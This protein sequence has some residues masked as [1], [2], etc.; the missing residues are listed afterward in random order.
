MRVCF[1]TKNN[2]AARR[3]VSVAAV[4][5]TGTLLA[6]GSWAATVGDWQTVVNNGDIVPG[7]T[8][9]S[10]FSYNQPS[11]SSNGLV[12]FRARARTPGGGGGGGEPFR[13]IY[14]RDMSVPGQPIV[15]I[16]DNKSSLVP[17]P[18]NTGSGFAEFPSFPRIDAA[19][20]VAF[21]G[22]SQPVWTYTDANG[23]DTK[24]GTSGVY[25]AP[26]GV[27]VTGA[28]QLGAVPGFGHASVPGSAAAGTKFDQ[29][30]GAPSPS[31]SLVAFKGNWTDAA[32][33][34][35]GIYVR[36][37]LAGGGTD[38]VRFIAESG[39]AIPNEGGSAGSGAVFGSTAP[40]STWGNKVVFTGLDNEDAPTAGGI[41]IANMVGT[42]NLRPLV[43]F[44]TGVP[45]A[46]GQTFNK[47]GEALSYD[48]NRV[49][50]WAAWGD[51]MRTV[52][53]TCSTDGNAAVKQACMD[54]SDK[55]PVT[56]EA[57]G[58]TTRDVPVNQGIFVVNT[59][60]GVVE[61][62]A[63]TGDAG[64]SD[65]L[66][67]NFSGAPPGVGEGEGDAEAPRWRSTSF[68][69]VDGNQ[70]IFKAAG[71]TVQ[72]LMLDRGIGEMFATLVDTTMLA[73]LLDPFAQ[74][75]SVI[76]SF[77]IERDG[78]RAGRIAIN[79][80][81]LNAADEGWAGIYTAN[82][83]PIPLP[84]PLLL[85]GAALGSLNLLRR[86]RR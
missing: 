12:V 49:G 26:A 17:D 86:R 25:A 73:S 11:I 2:G 44:S 63:Q 32:G 37:V 50:F 60:T 16:A 64:V 19:G 56:G 58:Q 57:T 72:S 14:S 35:T 83:A 67:W 82:V 66:F 48:G 61:M 31:G 4:L 18:N 78:F 9:E 55:D 21:R 69:A 68:V 74:L 84:L 36:D 33:G 76:T 47:I 27:L 34:R 62:V 71:E 23:A 29:F 46:A 77:G 54:S 43:D 65:L 79:A 7:G 52:T 80:G 1:G 22:Q 30:P 8:T 40:P 15:L 70:T 24:A 45:G 5:L 75:G 41:Y 6:S 53:L 59:G 28:N 20:T 51:D 85:L 39:M 42:S 81:F 13:G 38:P 3:G 10:F